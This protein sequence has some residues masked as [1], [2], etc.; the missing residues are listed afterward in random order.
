MLPWFSFLS[1]CG[2]L[3]ANGS[4]GTASVRIEREGTSLDIDLG[5]GRS[6]FDVRSDFDGLG[7]PGFRVTANCQYEVFVL[8][9]SEVSLSQTFDLM[10]FPG[11][12][13]ISEPNMAGSVESNI[14]CGAQLQ[15]VCEGA[16]P[17]Y[18]RV[19]DPSG[20]IQY[21]LNT[22]GVTAAFDMTLGEFRAVGSLDL[23]ADFV[24]DAE[25]CLTVV[26]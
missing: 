21:T 17:G 3:G 10:D 9:P 12:I 13:V 23:P 5:V 16:D 18:A 2:L 26:P 7:F 15:E 1:G 14:Y 25:S 6:R 24:L 22:D 19:D 11:L 20:T 8:F 4:N